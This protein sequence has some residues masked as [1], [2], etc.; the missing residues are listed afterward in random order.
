MDAQMD[1]RGGREAKYER[2]RESR[3][4]IY[5]NVREGGGHASGAIIQQSA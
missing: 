2:E 5:N 4:Y 3:Q 1:T